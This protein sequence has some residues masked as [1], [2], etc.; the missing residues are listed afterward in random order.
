MSHLLLPMPKLTHFKSSLVELAATVYE[1]F[2]SPE[3]A[4]ITKQRILLDWMV[5][6][7]LN[8]CHWLEKRTITWLDSV[9]NLPIR[10]ER[11]FICA[12]TGLIIQE[13]PK[14]FQ[15]YKNED[16][17]FTIEE[18][19]EIKREV[20]GR[21][22]IFIALHRSMIRPKRLLALP[23]KPHIDNHQG[24]LCLFAFSFAVAFYGSSSRSQLVGLVTQDEKPSEKI[25]NAELQLDKNIRCRNTI[26]AEILDKRAI[27][28]AHDEAYK[29]AN[30]E[31]IDA[32]KLLR[33]KLPEIQSIQHLMK[34]VTSIEEI[35]TRII[36]EERLIELLNQRRYQKREI[37]E[38][39]KV[40]LE[41]AAVAQ[42]IKIG[43]ILIH[44]VCDNGQQVQN[45]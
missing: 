14:C 3:S 29:I 20:I 5:M 8:S 19:S 15:T 13:P 9:T 18:P 38:P 30:L 1:F 6:K 17:K 7:L 4:D 42:G 33:S 41:K 12:D 37:N 32:K 26:G 25:K 22:C 39:L 23:K 45:I 43:K 2:Y 31:Y 11:S 36:K 16:I 28:I 21:I 27:L 10:A 24:Y 35:D 44:R 34:N 40:Q